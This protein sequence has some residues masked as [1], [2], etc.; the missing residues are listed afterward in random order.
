MKKRFL[1]DLIMLVLTVSFGFCDNFVKK[2]ISINNSPY[3][4]TKISIDVYSVYVYITDD[5]IHNWILKEQEVLN[6]GSQ[7]KAKNGTSTA[8]SIIEDVSV[9]ILDK[10]DLNTQSLTVNISCPLNY[11]I[12][13]SNSSI[14]DL[15][16]VIENL[17]DY[18]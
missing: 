2:Q 11:K 9:T 3:S 7:L 12:D 4:V 8:E 10:K 1:L 14:E 17:E 13:A 16:L 6:Y 18:L 5:Y 15:S